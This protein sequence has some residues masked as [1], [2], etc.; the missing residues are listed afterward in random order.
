MVSQGG[1]GASAA[2]VGAREIYNTIFG[3]SGNKQIPE[4]VIKIAT[5]LPKISAATKVVE[6]SPS[7][8]P[9]ASSSATTKAKK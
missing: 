1:T 4:K 5:T 6:A 9:S 8:S 3:V 7:P 2:G